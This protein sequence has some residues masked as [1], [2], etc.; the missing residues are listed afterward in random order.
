[1]SASLPFYG[2]LQLPTANLGCLNL[3]TAV[4]MYPVAVC[5]SVLVAAIACV[6]EASWLTSRLKALAK[7]RPTRTPTMSELIAGSLRRRYA[8]TCKSIARQRA[9]F[10]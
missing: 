9:R 4:Q 8:R 2:C 1:M 7:K 6:L 10:Q 3:S 5:R